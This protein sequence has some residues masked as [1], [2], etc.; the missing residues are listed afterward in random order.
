MF[1]PFPRGPDTKML[2]SYLDE[3]RG[4]AH[5]MNGRVYTLLGN[6]EVENLMRK[7]DFISQVSCKQVRLHRSLGVSFW[8]QWY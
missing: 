7:L 8:L 1:I 3:L 6:H 2:F 5:L 4:E